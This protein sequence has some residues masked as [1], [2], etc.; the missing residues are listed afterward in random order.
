MKRNP[1]VCIALALFGCGDTNNARDV[2]DARIDAV[3]D[4][5]DA[6]PDGGEDVTPD[7]PD[8]PPQGCR[9]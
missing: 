8:V 7:V 3:D 5:V 4:A 6:A 2:V 1:L 9:I